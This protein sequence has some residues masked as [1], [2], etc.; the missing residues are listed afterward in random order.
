VILCSSSHASISITHKKNVWKTAKK[1]VEATVKQLASKMFESDSTDLKQKFADNIFY[2]PGCIGA[3]LPTRY[4][5]TKFSSN[6]SKMHKM[7]ITLI[8]L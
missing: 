3:I 8:F 5:K 1:K 7:I 4:A 6:K 2:K